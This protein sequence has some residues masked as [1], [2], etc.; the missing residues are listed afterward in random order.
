MLA[1]TRSLERALAIAKLVKPGTKAIA[2]EAIDGMG[3]TTVCKILGATPGFEFYEAKKKSQI[4][5][6]EASWQNNVLIP[7]C[8]ASK[9]VIVLDRT[10]LSNIVYSRFKQV[11]C[12][13]AK[14]ISMLNQLFDVL[15]MQLFYFPP[16][17]KELGAGYEEYTAKQRERIANIYSQSLRKLGA[18]NI[19]YS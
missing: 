6:G 5:E 1:N 8:L 18:D 15:S 10:W 4:D 2:C 13:E 12:N 7:Y 16:A 9:N 17:Q 19:H 3:K 14:Q 11:Y